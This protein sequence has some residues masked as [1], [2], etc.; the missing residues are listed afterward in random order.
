VSL[1]P[2]EGGYGGPDC[3][4]LAGRTALQTL[5]QYLGQTDVVTAPSGA[6]ALHLLGQPN[7]ERDGPVIDAVL[8]RPAPSR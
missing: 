6:E 2:A 3:R 7:K 8:R 4:G 1:R 5:L